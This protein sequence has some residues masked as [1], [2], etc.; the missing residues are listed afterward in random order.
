M[1]NKSAGVRRRGRK[2][3]FAVNPE[4]AGIDKTT[5]NNTRGAKEKMS[6]FSDRMHDKIK[7]YKKK[8]AY[9]NHLHYKLLGVQIPTALS[10]FFR[11]NTAR[12]KI[13]VRSLEVLPFEF[14]INLMHDINT[15]AIMV[16]IGFLAISLWMAFEEIAIYGGKQ[17]L[18]T[19][20]TTV[21]WIQVAI[22]LV[23]DFIV[24]W[25]LGP[26]LAV[27][28]VL[29][30]DI[31]EFR[32]FFRP[33]FTDV[34]C[35]DIPGPGNPFPVPLIDKDRFIPEWWEYMQKSKD[36][37]AEFSTGL[38]ELQVMP[39]LF[40]SPLV[41]PILHHVRPV[42]WLLSLIHISEPTRPR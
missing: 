13:L 11:A 40:L 35:N 39:K 6:L 36:T 20:I 18:G 14:A 21:Y 12:F 3:S 16:F 7:E 31:S 23:I 32:T 19:I 34:I 26:I 8:T 4:D 38:E 29:V 42:P 2:V 10:N 17:V 25:I 22:E 41:C 15:I 37:C 28:Q 30:C 9:D 27:V 1:A 24:M 5:E 33:D